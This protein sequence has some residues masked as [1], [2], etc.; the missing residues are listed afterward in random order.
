MKMGR[1]QD[2]GS[3]DPR[4][5]ASLS[6]FASSQVIPNSQISLSLGGKNLKLFLP[7]KSEPERI[8]D[9]PELW[10][11]GLRMARAIAWY[12]SPPLL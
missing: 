3:Q 11:G 12:R 4:P 2:S 5:R 8:P 1:P 6:I 10:R 7:L 9:R